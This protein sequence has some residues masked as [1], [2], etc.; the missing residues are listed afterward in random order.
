M[1]L[2]LSWL[3]GNFDDRGSM[4]YG[5]NIFQSLRGCTSASWHDL[6]MWISLQINFWLKLHLP[7]LRSSY[8]QTNPAASLEDL[9]G[10]K[11]ICSVTRYTFSTRMP[12]CRFKCKYCTTVLVTWLEVTLPAKRHSVMSTL[13]L[14]LLCSPLLFFVSLTYLERAKHQELEQGAPLPFKAVLSHMNK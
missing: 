13:G 14:S 5:Y 11:A 7:G 10:N 2:N 1:L 9:F 3:S 8:L 6:H 4:I 12:Q